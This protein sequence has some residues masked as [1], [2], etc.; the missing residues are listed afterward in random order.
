[1]QYVKIHAQCLLLLQALY[2]HGSPHRTIIT[3][4]LD[5]LQSNSIWM[6]AEAVQGTQRPRAKA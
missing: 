1:M 3:R 2:R 4:F 6:Y 5:I